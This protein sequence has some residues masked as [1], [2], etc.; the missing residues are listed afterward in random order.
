MPSSDTPCVRIRWGLPGAAEDARLL[1]ATTPVYVEALTAAGLEV[2]VPDHGPEQLAKT[3]SPAWLGP[4]VEVAQD[5]SVALLVDTL[6]TVITSKFSDKTQ[7][8]RMRMRIIK[9]A[10]DGA[11]V[12]HEMEGTADEVRE[13]AAEIDANG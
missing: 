2:T 8:A 11:E 1:P 7:A 10:P 6:R 3:K 4:I 12:V 9:T 5:V 13:Q